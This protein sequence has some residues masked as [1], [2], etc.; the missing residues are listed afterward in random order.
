MMDYAVVDEVGCCVQVHRGLAESCGTDHLREGLRLV[1]LPEGFKDA[2][3]YFEGD[4][5]VPF[6][7]KPSSF[8]EWDWSIKQWVH[9]PQMALDSIRA[10]RGRLLQ[11]CDWTQLPDVPGPTQAAWSTYRQALRDITQQGDLFNVVWPTAP[12]K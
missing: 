11:A 7:P 5:P 1:E 12:A 4:T 8:C 6:P 9:K 10:K 3:H 2:I